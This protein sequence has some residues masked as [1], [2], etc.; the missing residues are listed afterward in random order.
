MAHNQFYLLHPITAV[1][2]D[3]KDARELENTFP[4]AD[5]WV[6]RINKREKSNTIY[7]PI[8]NGHSLIASA[9]DYIWQ[10]H[11]GHMH[12]TEGHKFRTLVSNHKSM[13]DIRFAS[14]M[15]IALCCISFVTG[16]IFYNFLKF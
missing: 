4:G 6:C 1:Y 16:M 13:D 12:V 10:D 14:V 9:G 2:Y 11:E 7:I 3:G 5:E 15:V 8:G